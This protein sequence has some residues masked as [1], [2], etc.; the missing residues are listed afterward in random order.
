MGGDLVT[1]AVDL[2]DTGVVGVFVRN[3]EGGLNVAAVGVFAHAV[4]HVPVQ[5][6]VVVVD[7]VVERHHDHLGHLFRIEFAWNF[8][9]SFGAEAIGQQAD[10]WIAS[11]G[12]VRIVAQICIQQP[13]SI[14]NCT[15]KTNK[16]CLYRKS[17]RPIHRYSLG[18]R[19]R[20]GCARCKC[21]RDR[22]TCLPGRGARQWTRWASIYEP[23]L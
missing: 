17:S 10:G 22:P 3:E 14:A 7:G 5:F 11:R 18:R 9:A 1:F 12:S 16:E 13:M 21:R 20:R 23:S 8:R 6:D 19:C 2:L 15:Q 4:E